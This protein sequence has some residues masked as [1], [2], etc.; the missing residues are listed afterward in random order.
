M[1][2]VCGVPSEWIPKYLNQMT[3]RVVSENDWVLEGIQGFVNSRNGSK[4][5]VFAQNISEWCQG[6]DDFLKCEMLTNPRRLGRYMQ[7]HAG[8]IHNL[9][10][11]AK[12][13]QTNNR[14]SYRIIPRPKA[15]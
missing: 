4:D 7:S 2:K 15:L 12:D 3:D 14:Q 1:A 8:L 13:K 9:T 10:G 6:E 5:L 11:L